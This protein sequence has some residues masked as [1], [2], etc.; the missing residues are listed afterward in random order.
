MMK[1]FLIFLK[2]RYWLWKNNLKV[3]G[4]KFGKLKVG[5]FDCSSCD[6]DK[7]EEEQ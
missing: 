5:D 3:T 6:C 1:S 2:I 7:I 4:W